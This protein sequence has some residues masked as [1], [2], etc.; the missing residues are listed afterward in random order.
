MSLTAIKCPSCRAPMTCLSSLAYHIIGERCQSEEHKARQKE[1]DDGIIHDW[2]C[3]MK[4]I[5]VPKLVF[6]K[7]KGKLR[8][9]H[10]KIQEKKN[11][12]E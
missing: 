8:F 10:Q 5:E 4:M 12:E 7:P 2:K 9:R 1:Y 3:K 11:A 6:R